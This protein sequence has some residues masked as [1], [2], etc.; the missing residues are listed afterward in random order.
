M[1][2][3]LAAQLST[4]HPQHLSNP[5]HLHGA[6]PSRIAPVRIHVLVVHDG[7][8]LAAEQHAGRVDC[9]RLVP[10][11]RAVAPVGEEARSAGRK[12]REE[13]PQDCNM[14]ALV[15]RAVGDD[16]VGVR[17][18]KLGLFALRDELLADV[19]LV[20]EWLVR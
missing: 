7:L 19:L 11:D 5:V 3:L 4:S 17:V 15:R 18:E 8:D 13:A 16:G 20:A 1:Y 6:D 2:L 9:D 14:V 12:A 10:H